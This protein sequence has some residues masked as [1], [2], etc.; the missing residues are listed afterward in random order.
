MYA[1]N[2]KL[3]DQTAVHWDLRRPWCQN[4]P[5]HC[6]AENS[7]RP[8]HKILYERQ[9]SE[10]RRWRTRTIHLRTTYVSICESQMRKGS[11]GRS[12]SHRSENH[13][14]IKCAEPGNAKWSMLAKRDVVTKETYV[15]SIVRERE[16]RSYGM[17]V[18]KH[19]TIS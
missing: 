15:L 3:G 2:G 4:H 1:R 13:A 14:D 18:A 5:S 16:D 8:A 9:M 11:S 19:S 12:S 6:N 7:R 10:T 17:G